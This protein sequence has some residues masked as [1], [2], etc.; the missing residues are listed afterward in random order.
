M[1]K[2]SDQRKKQISD[3]EFNKRWNDIFNS[4]HKKH[5]KKNNPYKNK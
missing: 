3:D 1:S 2:G 4:P 5:W